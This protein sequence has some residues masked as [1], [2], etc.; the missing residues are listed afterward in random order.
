MLLFIFN[1]ISSFAEE[2]GFDSQFLEDPEFN[3]V[4]DDLLAGECY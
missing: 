1:K 2:I 3:N 4:L